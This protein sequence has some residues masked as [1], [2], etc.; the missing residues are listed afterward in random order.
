MNKKILLPVVSLVAT[1]AI[2]LFFV[3]DW[4]GDKEDKD[5]RV[6]PGSGQIAPGDSALGDPPSEL[7]LKREKMLKEHNEP[8]N[9]V[10]ISFD[11]KKNLFGESVIEGNLKNKAE[12]TTYSDF[13][14]MIYFETQEG[15]TLDSAQQG[16]F[17][18]LE[19]GEK[20]EFR[21]KAKGPRKGKVVTLM[22]SDAKVE[23]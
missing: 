15:V 8:E 12:Y 4:G 5:T 21:L 9:F 14:M 7:E 20:E 13:D 10:D 23:Q 22:I 16:I 17:V 1:A 6:R 2:V 11:Y 19:P 3:V 18:A